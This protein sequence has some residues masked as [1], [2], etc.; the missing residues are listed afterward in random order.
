MKILGE[1]WSRFYGIEGGLVYEGVKI[2]LLE[3]ITKQNLGF[4]LLI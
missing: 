3:M 4:L 2:F 1:V